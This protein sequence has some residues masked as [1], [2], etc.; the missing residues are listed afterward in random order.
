A[1][2]RPAHR[3]RTWPM[4][5]P[6]RAFPGP[7]NSIREFHVQRPACSPPVTTR[8]KT[9]TPDG[10]SKSAALDLP[11]AVTES[12]ASMD[13]PERPDRT[14]E[15]FPWMAYCSHRLIERLYG[16]G[17][18]RASR[19]HASG[20]PRMKH[21]AWLFPALA[22][23]AAALLAGAPASAADMVRVDRYESGICA[24]RNV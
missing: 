20:G 6:R 3:R 2:R 1:G 10:G 12:A 7:R 9:S 16:A 17:A 4:P 5:P 14:V 21:L 11:E 15:A 18:N 19:Q 23:A 22:A 13:S 8:A 24:N